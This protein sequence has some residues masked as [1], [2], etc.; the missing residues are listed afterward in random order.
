MSPSGV[1]PDVASLRSLNSLSDFICRRF[2][3]GTCRRNCLPRQ[4]GRSFEFFALLLRREPKVEMRRMLHHRF[5]L[6]IRVP[7][8]ET[9]FWETFVTL[10]GLEEKYKVRSRLNQE[11]QSSQNTI[12]GRTVSGY[13]QSA[14]SNKIPIADKVWRT[15]LAR[16]ALYF[17]NF[18]PVLCD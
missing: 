3:R 4:V 18:E 8:E 16:K 12:S 14:R 11:I 6:F 1:R 7:L 15:N 9:I 5:G 2:G 10:Q 17:P 13:F